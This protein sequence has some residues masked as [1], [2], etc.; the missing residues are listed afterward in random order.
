MNEGYYSVFYIFMKNLALFVLFP[1]VF[2]IFVIQATSNDNNEK[3]FILLPEIMYGSSGEAKSKDTKGKIIGL[4]FSASWCSSCRR[5][6][7]SLV[8]F[9]NQNL[10]KFEVEKK[11]P[12]TST[13]TGFGR[14]LGSMWEGFW[15]VWGVC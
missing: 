1:L 10:E 5:F 2:F 14:V 7:P 4:Y 13:D 15:R 8:T 3:E 9:R 11:R 6:N 12:K